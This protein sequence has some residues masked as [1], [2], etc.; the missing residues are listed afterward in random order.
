MDKLYSV[1]RFRVEP[2]KDKAG[3]VTGDRIRV[4]ETIESNMTW[5]KAK[6]LRKLNKG[7]QIFPQ[8]AKQRGKNE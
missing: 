1:K 8:P 4:L 5:D 3:K 6:E 7:Y 2:E